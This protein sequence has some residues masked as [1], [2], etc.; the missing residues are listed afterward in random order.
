[1]GE[2]VVKHIDAKATLLVPK[3]DLQVDNVKLVRMAY[4]ALG[5][6]LFSCASHT[7]ALV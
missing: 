7:N 3:E 2:K 4:V 1:M 5:C 6:T